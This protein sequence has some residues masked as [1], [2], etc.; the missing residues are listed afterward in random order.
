MYLQQLKMADFPQ[1]ERNFSHQ[2]VQINIK[3]ILSFQSSG[4]DG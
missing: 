4:F 2:K 3:M 1:I